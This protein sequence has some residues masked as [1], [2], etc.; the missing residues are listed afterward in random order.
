[1]RKVSCLLDI[2]LD[3]KKQKAVTT[4]VSMIWT[5]FLRAQWLP[6]HILLVQ[7]AVLKLRNATV[8]IQKSSTNIRIWSRRTYLEHAYAS[9]VIVA[10]AEVW[11][12]RYGSTSTD[13]HLQIITAIQKKK[14]KGKSELSFAQLFTISRC[15]L[16]F[17]E[18]FP[19][20]P[21][22]WGEHS[23]EVWWALFDYVR[24]A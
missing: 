10:E 21:S 2:S 14:T 7:G 6:L 4:E 8:Q 24:T 22:M 19:R 16:W 20:F 12:S 1:M 3:S 5:I 18:I 15:P 9:P 11:G 13:I 17:Y 23:Q